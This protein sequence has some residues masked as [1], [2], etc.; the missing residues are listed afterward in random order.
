[1]NLSARN[2]MKGKVISVNRGA[3]ST[4]VKIEVPAPAVMSAT[5]TNEAADDLALKLGDAVT[6]IVKASEVIIG[7]E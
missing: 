1:M 6:A 4:I 3:V 7:K 2:Q 5:I